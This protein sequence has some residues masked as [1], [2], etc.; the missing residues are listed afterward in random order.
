MEIK[1]LQGFQWINPGSRWNHLVSRAAQAV[2]DP[3][4]IRASL[5]YRLAQTKFRFWI[6]PSYWKY[7][8][9]S[10][11]SSSWKQDALI[12]CL[13][14]SVAVLTRIRGRTVAQTY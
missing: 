4:I 1:L 5:I 12:D 6:Y 3:R 7:L 8:G 13:L 11:L 2:K 9:T 10:T 14:L